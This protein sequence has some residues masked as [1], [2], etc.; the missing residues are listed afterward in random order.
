VIRLFIM[1]FGLVML[2]GACSRTPPGPRDVESAHGLKLPASSRNFQHKRSGGMLDHG[3]LSLFEI[4]QGDVKGFES[5]LN[6]RSRDKPTLAGPGNPCINGWNVWPQ[7]ASTFVPGNRE[8]DVLKPT[9]VGPA[10]PVEMLSCSSTKGDWLHVE[11]WSADRSV[12][13]KLY[14]DSN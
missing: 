11:I 1:A 7:T 5:Q 6:V 9:W 10:K 12:I 8:F 2:F 14:T 3:V 4:D 13:V